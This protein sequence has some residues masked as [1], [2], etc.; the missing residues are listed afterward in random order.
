[1]TR[2]QHAHFLTQAAALEHSL[3]GPAHHADTR[4]LL[5]LVRVIL[6]LDRPDSGSADRKLDQILAQL[7]TIV[8]KENQI[9]STE[10]DLQDDLDTIKAGVSG[11]LTAA[12]ANAATI[13]D[14]KAQLAAGTPVSQAQLDALDTQAKAIV[15]TLTPLVPA[16]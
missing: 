6:D 15:A 8:A 7:A 11:L 12:T 14:L 5:L 4:A 9:M 2:D 1:M 16:A 13:A 10:Q 3:Q